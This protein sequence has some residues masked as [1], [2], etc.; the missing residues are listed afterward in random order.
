MTITAPF[1]VTI[2]DSATPPA[3]AGVELRITILR[4]GPT[5]TPIEGSCIV[6]VLCKTLVAAGDG[7]SPPY[8]FTHDTFAS[9]PPPLGTVILTSGELSG[10]IKTEGTYSFNIC[11]VDLIGEFSCGTT[12]VTVLKENPLSRFDGTYAGSYSGSHPYGTESGSVTLTVTDGSIAGTATGAI[13]SLLGSV[14]AA[15]SASLTVSGE[16][17]GIATGT[18]SVSGTGTSVSGTFS[19]TASEFGVTVSGTW[20]ATRQ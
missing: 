16:C 12:S 17:L 18:F 19:C 2:T 6:N 14:D 10:T 8:H 20:S 11:V 1:T 3:S 5:L 4:A 9:N 7:G 13:T 15:G